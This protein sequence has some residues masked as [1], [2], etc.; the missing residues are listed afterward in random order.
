M[1]ERC[2]GLSALPADVAAREALRPCQQAMV[3]TPSILLYSTAFLQC[4]AEEKGE[5]G[6]NNLLGRKWAV[7]AV[8]RV[9]VMAN[10]KLV[11]HGTPAQVFSRA[12]ELI[13]VG[14]DV[15]QITRVAR[16]LRDA[17]VDIGLDIYTVKFAAH[18]LL[19]GREFK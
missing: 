11:M 19:S 12:E 3:D 5:E 16:A 13:A 8:D 7:P 6:L 9:L 14:L 17:G 15:P 4:V 2:Y 10:G 1:R 18:R